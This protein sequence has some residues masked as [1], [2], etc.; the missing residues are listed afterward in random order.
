[1]PELLPPPAPPRVVESYVDETVPPAEPSPLE[2]AVDAPPV[3][4]PPK[5]PAPRPDATA[6]KP[7]PPQP[8]PERPATPPPSLTIKPAPGSQSATE[9][10]IRDL[11]SRAT[12]DLGRVNYGSLTGDGKAQYDTARRFV[13]QS[14]DALREGNL[15]LAGKLADKAETMA[16]MLVR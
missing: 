9:A 14:E 13:Q 6:V 1:M 11:L 12:R 4:T 2:T 16:S 10:S 15:V 8:A 7:E 5:P 3:R